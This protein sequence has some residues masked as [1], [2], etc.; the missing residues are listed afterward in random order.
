MDIVDLVKNL[1]YTKEHY[2]WLLCNLV[3][4]FIFAYIDCATFTKIFNIETKKIKSPI[5]K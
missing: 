2:T 5:I 4:S 1:I 3:F